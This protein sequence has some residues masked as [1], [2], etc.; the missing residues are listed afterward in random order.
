MEDIQITTLVWALNFSQGALSLFVHDDVFCIAFLSAVETVFYLK[1]AAILVLKLKFS[2]HFSATLWTRDGSICT[3]LKM[4]RDF[5]NLTMPRA[6]W[7]GA[8]CL[9]ITDLFSVVQIT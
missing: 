9:Q 8:F 4:F 1:W 3:L 2:Q 5:F 7:C 6:L